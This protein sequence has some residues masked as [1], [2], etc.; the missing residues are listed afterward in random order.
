VSLRKARKQHASFSSDSHRKSGAP[1]FGA[2]LSPVESYSPPE[3]DKLTP[4]LYS[5]KSLDAREK[6]ANRHN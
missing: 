6:L 3:P 1:S 5:W 4:R 2:A